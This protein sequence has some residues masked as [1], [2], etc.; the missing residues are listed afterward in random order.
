MKIAIVGTGIAGLTTAYHLHPDHDISVFEQ[1]GYIG[2]HAN[3]IVVSEAEREIALDTGFLVYNER[4]YP[5][6]TRLLKQLNVETQASEM[7]FSVR[8]SRCAVEYCGHNLR[9]LFARTDQLFRPR[10]HRM[11]F[12]ILRFNRAGRAWLRNPPGTHVT[13]G[14]FLRE[15]RFSREF[16]RHYVTPMASAIWSSTTADVEQFPLEFFL[17][18]FENHGMLSI[19]QHPQWRTITGGSRR[20]VAALT[21]GFADR[22]HLN[23][24]VRA[25]RR[26]ADGVTLGFDGGAVHT[27]DKVVIAAHSSQALRLLADPGEAEARALAALRYQANEAVLHTDPRLLPRNSNAWAAWNYHMDDCERLE[28]PLPMTYYLNRLQSIDSPTNYC[29]T[30]N[31]RGAI[32]RDHII[33]RIAYEHPV[34]T[35][36]SLQAQRQL[37]QLN[38]ERHTYYCGAYLGFG[39]HE[40]GVKSGLDVAR[41]V[42]ASRE[43]A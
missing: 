7:S 25:I 35:P 14:A 8:C 23:R 27:F 31:D 37:Q 3:T 19:N 5:N 11:L 2:G 6:F 20:Y 9:G 26:H 24:G 18:F 39:F 1:N 22:I 10:F 15:R 12:E 38:G 21:K 34:Y 30:L 4:T 42:E 36:T 43:A 40:D 13:V 32:R 28:Q 41:S 29:V 17:R 16:V 33:R